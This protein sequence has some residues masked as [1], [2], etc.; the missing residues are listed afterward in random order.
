MFNLAN[1]FLRHIEIS[2]L[3]SRE[4]G[5]I[6]NAKKSRHFDPEAPIKGFFSAKIVIGK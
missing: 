5:I 1:M 4:D 6:S 2:P 3:V